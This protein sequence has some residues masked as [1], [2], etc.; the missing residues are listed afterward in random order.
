MKRILSRIILPIM[1][2][3]V[4]MFG[5][6]G[7]ASAASTCKDTGAKGEVLQGVG[8]TGTNCSDAGVENTVKV[9]VSILSYIIG[10]LAVIMIMV[11]GFKYITSSGDSNA[12]ANAKNTIVYALV[13]IVIA[14]L[15]QFFVRFVLNNVKV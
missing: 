13:G 4:L 7:V 6:V 14:A 12:V 11:G 10:V 3:I 5:Q 1:A 15:A 9:V 2:G 8:Q